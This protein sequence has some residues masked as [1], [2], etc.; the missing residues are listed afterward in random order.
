[1]MLGGYLGEA[2]YIPGI[3]GFLLEVAGWLYIVFEIFTGDTCKAV[4]SSSNKPLK[5]S[6]P[7]IR[8]IVAVGWAVYPLGYLLGYL[9][10]G[11]D[12]NSLNVIYN[13]ID[14]INKIAFV[15]VIWVCAMQNTNVSKR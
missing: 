6:F 13:L 7:M 2:G 15:I 8:L 4:E 3:I 11:L 10:S 5:V 9:T 12:T 14:F 1:M